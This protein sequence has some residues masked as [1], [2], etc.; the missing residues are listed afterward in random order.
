VTPVGTAASL[1][2]LV[3]LAAVTTAALVVAT[4]VAVAVIESMWTIC[5][6]IQLK[7]T[8]EKVLAGKLSIGVHDYKFNAKSAFSA[9]ALEFLIR[10][11][12]ATLNPIE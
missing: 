2:G 8:S 4:A 9:L 11:V 7:W 3:T 1:G 6:I 10:P 12:S 5:S